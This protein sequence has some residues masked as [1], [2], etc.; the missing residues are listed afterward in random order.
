MLLVS[1]SCGLRCSE[2]SDRGILK[3]YY[4]FCYSGKMSIGVW[5][6]Y[7]MVVAGVEVITAYSLVDLV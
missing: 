6:E 7:Y 1:V 4:V 5:A 3:F 2:I